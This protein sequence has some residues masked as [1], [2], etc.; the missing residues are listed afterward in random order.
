MEF[1]REIPRSRPEAVVTYCEWKRAR[2]ITK[3]YLSRRQLTPGRSLPSRN[4]KD[5]PPPVE[6]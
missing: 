3:N 6:M 1:F 2:N 4:S 5:A